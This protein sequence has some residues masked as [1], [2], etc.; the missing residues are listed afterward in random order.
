MRYIIAIF[1]WVLTLNASNLEITAD[2]FYHKDGDKK[3]EFQGHV[4]AKEGNNLIKSDKIIIYLDK[5]NEAYKYEAIGKV[6]FE[7]KS[8][9]KDVTGS[10][11]KLIYLPEQEIYTLTG[12][13]AMHDNLNKRDVYGDE[14]ILDNKKK[15]SI[16]KSNGKK[17]VKFLFK[18]KGK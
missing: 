8:S 15:T 12:N 11:N 9:K 16:A 1:L 17:P 2:N 3:A 14:V 4:I 6:Y 10:C 18:V 7:I 5:N 13:V